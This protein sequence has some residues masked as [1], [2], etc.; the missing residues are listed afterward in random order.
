VSAEPPRT[1]YVAEPRALWRARP[2]VVVDCSVMA[3]ML[4]AEP[5]EGEAMALL[6]G[7][8]L[9]APALLP[10][11]LANVGVKKRRG[12]ATEA[13]VETALADLV[14]QRVDLHPVAPAAAVALAERFRLSA[15]DAAYLQLAAA[16]NAPL[17]TFDQRLA[18]AAR[19]HLGSLE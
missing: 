19:R 14:D 13:E 9:H 18:D 2:P 1:L 5:A 17:V 16:L 15:Y 10:F 11:E 8:A 12:G 6:A 4:F 3:A 7:R